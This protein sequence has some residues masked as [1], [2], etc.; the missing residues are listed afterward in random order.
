MH[1]GQGKWYPG[2]AA[3]ALGARL[4]LA[5]ATASRPGATRRSFAD[6]TRRRRPRRRRTPS[7][8]SRALA[9][10]LGVADD[11]RAGRL[12]G[13]LVLPLARA[14]AARQ[15]RSLRR[16]ARRR[17]GARAP[18]RASSTQGLDAVVG[19]ALPLARDRRGRRAGAAGPWFLRERAPVPDPRRLA[20]GLSPAARLAAVGG[21]RRSTPTSIERDPIAPRAPLPAARRDG[22]AAQPVAGADLRRARPG[23]CGRRRRRRRGRPR[24]RGSSRRRGSCA[25]RSASSRATACSTSSCRR[26]TSLEDYLELV[27]A[28]EATRRDARH[29]GAARRLPA[30]ARSAAARTSWSRPIPA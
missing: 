27:A 3:P 26:S 9:A 2:R 6:E 20:D 14:A 10:R 18:A 23:R 8:S 25:P 22:A 13:R 7:A 1:F 30:A 29:A 4:L 11:A 19:Y 28:V 15:R 5:R 12:R 21:G 16:A 17:D 24:R